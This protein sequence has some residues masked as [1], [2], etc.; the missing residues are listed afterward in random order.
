MVAQFLDLNNL[1]LQR[2]LFALSND[3]R[4]VWPTVFMHK[5][6]TQVMP[7]F[8]FRF[9]LPYFQDHS[10]VDFQILCYHSNVTKR[11]PSDKA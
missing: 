1:S 11:F 8:F 5:K 10:F 3:E 4:K 2:K 6:L 9:I 7:V